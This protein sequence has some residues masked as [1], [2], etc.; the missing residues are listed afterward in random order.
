MKTKYFLFLVI[1]ASVL[2]ILISV[3]GIYLLAAQAITPAACIALILSY[4]IIMMFILIQKHRNM[5]YWYEQLLDHMAQPVSVTDN[6]MNWTFINKPVEDMLQ[7]KRSSVVGQHCSN[8]GAP[9]CNTEKC[10]I[11]CLRNGK[12]QTLFDQLN[13]NFK[14]DSDYLYNLRGKKIGHIEV[15]TEITDEVQLKNLKDQ[16]KA[17]VN[18]LVQQLTTN[19]QNLAASS[20]E[21]SSSVEEITAS[22]ELNADNAGNTEHTANNASKETRESNSAVS[23]A[24]NAINSIVEKNTLV[25]DIASQTNLLALN[26][27]IEAARAGESG[28]GFAVVAT[29]VRKLAEKSQAAANEI[30]ELTKSTLAI[31]SKA[32]ERLEQLIPAISKTSELVSE[33]NLASQEQKTGMQ[34]INLAVQEVSS[35]AES[36]HILAEKLVLIIQELES[37]GEKNQLE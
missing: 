12:N 9:I 23:E 24:I 37:F 32:G 7:L 15:V 36:V 8:W 16:I 30:E 33:I 35:I 4:Y 31:S 6:N 27:A 18:D 2:F 22:I 29:E 28:K 26:A 25:Q 17:N 1:I 21:V 3:T 13:M 20:E 14:V 34:Q 5:A 10:G 19:A 11:E